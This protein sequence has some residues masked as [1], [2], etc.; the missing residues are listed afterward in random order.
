[1]QEK[2]PDFTTGSLLYLI[3]ILFTNLPSLLF[4]Y[5]INPS[6]TAYVIERSPPYSLLHLFQF[7]LTKFI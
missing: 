7:M 4:Q 6:V 2:E 1:M 5:W 3:Q